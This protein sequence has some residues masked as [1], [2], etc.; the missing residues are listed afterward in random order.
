VACGLEDIALHNEIAAACIGKGYCGYSASA[1][2][3]IFCL[4]S[5]LCSIFCAIGIYKEIRLGPR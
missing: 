5:N 2:A 4:N 1:S 3:I